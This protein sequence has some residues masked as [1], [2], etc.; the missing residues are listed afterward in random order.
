MRLPRYY[1]SLEARI[2]SELQDKLHRGRIEVHVRREATDGGQQVF[3][4]PQVAEQYL[5]AT[6]E[7]AKRLLRDPIEIP[8]T[9]IL[10]QP[11]VLTSSEPE[12]DVISEWDIVATALDSAIADLLEMR[13]IEGLN[14]HKEMTSVLSELQRTRVE[15]VELADSVN[16]RIH[17]KL[18]MRLM[19][20]L[21]I[22]LMPTG[23]HKKVPF[24]R[25]NLIFL[26]N[27]FV[28]NHT[29]IN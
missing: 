9:F 5:Q 2:K 26:K 8:L 4:N 20:C 17:K 28:F 10:Q 27:S 11:G 12:P 19:N 21:V 23:L 13:Y 22:I 14:T 6:Q 1:L 7:I 24:L 29:V 25:T 18:E 3:A 15:T 16:A